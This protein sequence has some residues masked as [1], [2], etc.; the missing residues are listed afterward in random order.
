MLLFFAKRSRS[1]FLR[2]RTK[3]FSSGKRYAFDVPMCAKKS[4]SSYQSEVLCFCSNFH[5][6][7]LKLPCSC[8]AKLSQNWREVSSFRNGAMFFSEI[9]V[10]LGCTTFSFSFLCVKKLFFWQKQFN[11]RPLTIL[12][13]VAGEEKFKEFLVF[14]LIQ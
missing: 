13:S 8:H 9:R 4:F 5:K 6:T 1:P 3:V 12:F 14:Y 11:D 7:K 10:P 2:S